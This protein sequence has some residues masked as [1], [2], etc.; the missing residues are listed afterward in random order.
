[1]EIVDVTNEVVLHCP[2]KHQHG[3]CKYQSNCKFLGAPVNACIP[4]MNGNCK[5][6]AKCSK[7]HPD[8]WKPASKVVQVQGSTN[9]QNSAV[10]EKKKN[11]KD[12]RQNNKV[13][14]LEKELQK[15]KS[16]RKQKERDEQLKK[17][18]TFE[19]YK[20][21]TKMKMTMM[22]TYQQQQRD[23]D[24]LKIEAENKLRQQD[25][26]IQSAKDVATQANSKPVVA[27]GW[28]GIG[29]SVYCSQCACRRYYPNYCGHSS[30]YFN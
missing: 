18:I 27:I 11:K 17:E 19:M 5:F 24:L 4:F 23:L 6:G 8:N 10:V 28:H 12:S 26:A 16:K 20:Q 22:A 21:Q 14:Q 30:I 15:E 13:K 1:M 29:G 2:C 9:Q 25:M 3:D 7:M